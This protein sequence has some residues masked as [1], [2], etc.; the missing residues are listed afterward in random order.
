M[1]SISGSHFVA[2]AS[3]KTVNIVETS[4]GTLPPPVNGVFNLE[5]WIG[6][7]AD[8]PTQPAHDYQGLAVL[9]DGG[10]QIDLISGAFAVTDHG[11]G[12]DSINA[13]GTGESISGGAA[14]VTLNLFG[15]DDVANGGGTDTIGVFGDHDTVNAS[16][17]DS[18]SVFGTHDVVNGGGGRDTIG[19]FGNHDTVNAGFGNEQIYVFGS[20]DQVIGGTGNDTVDLFGSGDDFS[21][22]LG[23]ETI[24]AFGS[25]DSISDGMGDASINVLGDANTVSGGFGDDA[26]N[27]IGN[28][29]LI[30][31]GTGIADINVVGT[32]DTVDA[33]NHAFISE[34]QITVA[35]SDFQFN[36][37]SQPYF[38]TIVGFDQAAGDRIHLT[39]ES[40]H[41]ALANSKQ[42][43][44]GHD[45]LISLND[46]S[47]ILLKGVSHIDSGFFN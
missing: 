46:G 3:G 33:G 1:A 10:R 16:G 7:P 35:G 44:G 2:T 37:G 23:N 26:I 29:N 13:D 11:T 42:V 6:N 45:T 4:G 21:G 47:T 38:D 25:S 20:T 43:N 36:D 15:T 17:N 18:I 8:A 9:E 27:V 5:V 19:I 39:T 30:V 34:A 32:G 24:N 40:V 31:P 12:N 14:N 22:G 28:D 41:D